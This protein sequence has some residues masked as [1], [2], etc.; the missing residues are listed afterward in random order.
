MVVLKLEGVEKVGGN[1]FTVRKAQGKV[2]TSGWP[3]NRP[4][5]RVKSG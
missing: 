2:G 1:L 4:S 3:M 5:W